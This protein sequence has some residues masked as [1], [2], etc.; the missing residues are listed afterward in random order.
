[1]NIKGLVAAVAL[2]ASFAQVSAAQEMSLFRIG[3][4]GTR[5]RGGHAL[6]GVAEEVE[7]PG[8]IQ[9]GGAVA[10]LAGRG[11]QVGAG[12][13]QTGVG[14]ERRQRGRTGDAGRRA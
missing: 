12:T 4:G 2:A 6:A 1:M 3:T 7:L 5:L 8:R 10:L 9:R 14:I 11:R 13:L